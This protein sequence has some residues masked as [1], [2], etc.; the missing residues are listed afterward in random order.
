MQ[1]K[2]PCSSRKSRASREG[3]SQM[4]GNRLIPRAS[5]GLA[6]PK[7]HQL[8]SFSADISSPWKKK[9]CSPFIFLTLI[10]N[11]LP[12]S[13]L[14]TKE[15]NCKEECRR[16]FLWMSATDPERKETQSR[17]VPVWL[18][19]WS[20]M[21][22]VTWGCLPSPGAEDPSPS[23]RGNSRSVAWWAGSERAREKV[24]KKWKWSREAPL[25]LAQ[26]SSLH[27]RS[28]RT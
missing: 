5:G 14:G 16:H 11:K 10:M 22:C 9:K 7:V 20:I 8:G 26:Q 3:W 27:T 21:R 1:T 13:P 24:W 17:Q 23:K 4:L 6:A 19:A 12:S 28:P 18:S 25:P 2:V 15:Q